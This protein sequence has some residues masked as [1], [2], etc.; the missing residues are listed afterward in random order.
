M[1]IAVAN[2]QLTNT[3]DYWR[4]RTNDIAYI[5]STYAVT[6]Q[7][8]TTVGNAAITGTFTSNSLATNTIIT[9]SSIFIGNST[10]NATINSSSISLP[11]YNINSINVQTSNTDLQIVDYFDISSYR[12]AEYIISLKNN[13]ANAHQAA[14]LLVIHD[15]GDAYVTEYGVVSTNTSLGTFSANANSTHCRLLFTPTASN[16]QVKGIRTNVVV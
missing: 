5:I 7:S 9:D 6:T 14:K 13:A 1:T 11:N 3:Y 16:T 10:V 4:N 2:T 15:G 8:N 12:T